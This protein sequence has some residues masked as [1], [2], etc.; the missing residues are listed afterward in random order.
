MMSKLGTN[1]IFLGCPCLFLSC[2]LS[3]YFFYFGRVCTFEYFFLVLSMSVSYVFDDL[4]NGNTD[5]T[6]FLTDVITLTSDLLRC[7]LHDRNIRIIRIKTTI[8]PDI[9]IISVVGSN[10]NFN[11]SVFM[12]TESPS[13]T[14]V[15]VPDS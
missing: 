8:I 10:I 5:R 11:V 13:T 9:K 14:G 2:L 3:K 15:N 6:K 1:R 7:S 12:S 4:T